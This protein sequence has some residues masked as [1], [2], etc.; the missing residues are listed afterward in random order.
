MRLVHAIAAF[1]TAG[2]LS[3]EAKKSKS[4][5]KN[6]IAIINLG[7]SCIYPKFSNQPIYEDDLLTGSLEPTNQWYALAKNIVSIIK[8]EDN[9]VKIP[10]ITNHTNTPSLKAA[11]NPKKE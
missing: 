10:R 3:A 7:S 2:I 11:K 9:L 4:K 5:K 8:R 1:A 6:N